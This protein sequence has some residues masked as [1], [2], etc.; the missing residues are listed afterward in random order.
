MQ[1][2]PALPGRVLH[3]LRVC[4]SPQPCGAVLGGMSRDVQAVVQPEWCSAEESEFADGVA[5][6]LRDALQV[7]Q[8]AADVCRASSSICFCKPLITAAYTAVHW[9]LD[10]LASLALSLWTNLMPV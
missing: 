3:R 6:T 5:R 9:V 8:E 2:P 4:G 1:R 10:S 7:A